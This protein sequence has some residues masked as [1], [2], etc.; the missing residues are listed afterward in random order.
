[1]VFDFYKFLSE[2]NPCI[3]TEKVV[4]IT[5]KKQLDDFMKKRS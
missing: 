3:K 2:L 4:I 1:M 5:N